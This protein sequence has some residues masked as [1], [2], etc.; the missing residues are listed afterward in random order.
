MKSTKLISAVLATAL[1]MSALPAF[2]Q[3]DH[4]ASDPRGKSVQQQ[5]QDNRVERR[6]DIYERRDDRRDDRYERRDDRRDDRYERRD[7]RRDDRYERRA[8]RHDDRYDRRDFRQ[9]Q[10]RYYYN[11]RG[12]EFRRGA[13]LPREYR[14]QQYVVVNHR[15][16]RLAPPPHGQQWVQVGGDYVLVAIAT[17]IIASII[18]A[19]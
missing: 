10:R 7:D 15:V 18:L 6:E 1:G 5:R 4:G 3:H 9:D 17:G 13:Y 11:A 2:A 8:D 19:R 14:N 16:H 12:P